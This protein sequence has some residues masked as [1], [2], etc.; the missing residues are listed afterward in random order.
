[1]MIVHFVGF[2]RDVGPFKFCHVPESNASVGGST[3]EYGSL[4]QTDQLV[5]PSLVLMQVGHED[6]TGLPIPRGVMM[7]WKN[8]TLANLGSQENHKH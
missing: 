2:V 8:R 6:S 3:R 7:I 1:M 5:D 4:G